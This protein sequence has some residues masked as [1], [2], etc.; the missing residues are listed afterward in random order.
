MCIKQNNYFHIS[1]NIFPTSIKPVSFHLIALIQFLSLH[2]T[3]A[4]QLPCGLKT[5]VSFQLYIYI[6]VTLV[7]SFGFKECDRI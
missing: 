4:L 1:E 5:W 6:Q 7:L 2:R 3:K